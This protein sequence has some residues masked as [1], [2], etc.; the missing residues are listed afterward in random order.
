MDEIHLS[1]IYDARGIEY[2]VSAEEKNVLLAVSTTDGETIGLKFWG[3]GVWKLRALLD[4]L[5]Q[6]NPEIAQWSAGT[7]H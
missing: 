7:K 4:K 5:L 1:K 3:D 2:A 6:D